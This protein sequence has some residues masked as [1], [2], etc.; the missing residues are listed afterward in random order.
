MRYNDLS[1]GTY[2]NYKIV[3]FKNQLSH[4]YGETGA[5]FISMELGSGLNPESTA[6]GFSRNGLFF[7]TYLL[8]PILPLNPLFATNLLQKLVPGNEIPLLPFE[9]EAYEARIAEYSALKK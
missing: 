6:E 2:E 5:P 3:G 8:G 4:S 9:I 1:L 7:A